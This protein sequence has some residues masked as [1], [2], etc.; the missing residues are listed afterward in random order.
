MNNWQSIWQRIDCLRRSELF[1]GLAISLL[2]EVAEGATL[3][4]WKQ[5]R[6]L[7]RHGDPGQELLVVIHGD[8]EVLLPNPGGGPDVKVRNLGPGATVGE[9]AVFDNRPRT[10]TV[11]A[12][13]DSFC[14]CLKADRLRQLLADH[15]SFNLQFMQTLADRI[16]EKDRDITR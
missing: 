16:L 4:N 11:I 6:T 10:A 7:W 13:K 14:L 15:P 12:V 2:A 8:L 5:G 3:Q 1:A 9:V